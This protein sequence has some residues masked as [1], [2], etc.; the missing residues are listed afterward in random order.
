MHLRQ[1]LPKH[2]PDVMPIAAEHLCNP[3]FHQSQCI[4]LIGRLRRHN[5]RHD[6]AVPT[7]LM[8][9]LEVKGIIHHLIFC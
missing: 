7:R 9:I 8:K 1:D 3:I 2:V 5:D 4:R 6:C